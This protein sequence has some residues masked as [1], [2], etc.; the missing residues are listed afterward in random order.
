MLPRLL[1][2]SLSALPLAAQDLPGRAVADPA[3]TM[4]HRAIAAASR[5]PACGWTPGSLLKGGNRGA[6]VKPGSASS[7]LLIQAVRHTG[8][9]AMP[10][11]K[12]LPR[13]RSGFAGEVG[14]C[15]A[16]WPE[17]ATFSSAAKASKWWSFQT[18]CTAR[19]SR[20]FKMPVRERPSMLSSCRSYSSAKL[21]LAPEADRRTFIRRGLFRPARSASDRREDRGVRSGQIAGRLREAD[22]RAAGLAPLRREVGAPLARPGP[23]RRHRRVRAGSLSCSTPGAIATTSSSRSTTT[24]RTT[25]SSRNRS[26]ATSCIRTIRSPKAAPGY[27]HGRPEP[28]HAVQG[29]GRQPRSRR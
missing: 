26:P 16:S 15:G 17:A 9:L 13:R 8:K 20:P 6:A 21:Q 28:R 1:L 18:S 19:R 23:L 22:R 27:Y 5:C 10:P 14:G 4:R 12:K 25:A 2:V 7:S 11:G 3:S 29:R 24:S